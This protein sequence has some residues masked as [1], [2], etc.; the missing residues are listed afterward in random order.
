M[1][2]ACGTALLRR[3]GGRE[4][5]DQDERREHP[6]SH[7]YSVCHRSF[8]IS[9]GTPRS[10]RQSSPPAPTTGGIAPPAAGL[11]QQPR[12]DRPTRKSAN[13]AT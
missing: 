5:D 8:P 7:G 12:F 13:N 1:P 10:A 3:R 11:D 4:S 9:L 2:R 6:A